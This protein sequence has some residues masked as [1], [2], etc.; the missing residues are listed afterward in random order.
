MKW[1]SEDQL[2]FEILLS[3]PGKQKMLSQLYS[4]LL[5]KISHSGKEREKWEEDLQ[6]PF[7]EDEWLRLKII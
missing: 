1:Y 3:M 2:T 5:S 7:T 6:M 4:N